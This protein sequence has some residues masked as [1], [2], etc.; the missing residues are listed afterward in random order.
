MPDDSKS[1]KGLGFFGYI[2]LLIIITLS[3]VGV[4][5]IFQEEVLM[6]LPQTEYIFETFNNMIIIVEELIKSY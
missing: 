2:F 5:K 1:K 6:Y 4:L 3:V